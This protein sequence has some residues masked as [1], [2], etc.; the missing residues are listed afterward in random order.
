MIAALTVILIGTSSL[1]NAVANGDTRTLALYNNNTKESGTFTFKREGRYDPQALKQLNWFLR[2]W[3][4]SE[5]TD[6]DPELFDLVWEVYRDVGGK[7][8]ITVLSGYRSPC[9][10]RAPRAWPSRASTCAARPW[11]S[12][13]RAPT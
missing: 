5:P 6:M 8:G 11:T 12:T 10:A 3:R 1:Q 2:D 9:C 4:H 7:E 13:F